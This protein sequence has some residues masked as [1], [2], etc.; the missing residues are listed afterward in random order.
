MSNFKFERVDIQDEKGR[1]GIACLM[2][3]LDMTIAEKT[4]FI[5]MS[6]TA[7]SAQL[8]PPHDRSAE[9]IVMMMSMLAFDMEKHGMVKDHEIF[10]AITT[11]QDQMKVAASDK[12]SLIPR[13]HPAIDALKK[14]NKQKEEDGNE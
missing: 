13:T 7:M 12:A 4:A 1:T 3:P 10:E 2:N 6:S 11:L 9:S 5:L 8:K 14:M